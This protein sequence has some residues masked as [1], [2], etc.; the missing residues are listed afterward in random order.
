MARIRTI[1]QEFFQH[2]GMNELS[3]LHRL[4]FLGLLTEADR[5]GRLRDRPGLLKELLLPHDDCDV[6][7]LL[8]GLAAHRGRFLVRYQVEER[9]YI[10]ITGFAKHQRPNSREQPSTIPP[11]PG[12]VVENA[13]EVLSTCN[14]RAMHVQ[15]ACSARAMHVQSTC[16][17]RGEREGEW[18]GERELEREEKSLSARARARPTKASRRVPVDFTL[19]ADLEAFATERG[20]DAETVEAELGKFRDHEFKAAHSDWPAVWRNWVRNAAT[21]RQ[22]DGARG[23]AQ[24]ARGSATTAAG[25]TMEAIRVAFPELADET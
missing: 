5:E 15:S 6:D 10:A 7:E 16:N 18:E 3:A 25:R 21:Y 13:S 20:F 23:Y 24:P 1:K 14:A 12:E 17:A 22:R 8:T 2:E 9:Q 19:T 4:L 11:P